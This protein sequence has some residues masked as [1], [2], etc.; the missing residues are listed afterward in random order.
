MS[1]SIRKKVTVPLPYLL[2]PE[3]WM[4]LSAKQR[5]GPADCATRMSVPALSIIVHIQYYS[6]W[7]SLQMGRSH[8]S[9]EWCYCPS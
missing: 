7:T 6:C 3:S 9:A 1:G 4:T 2:S 8:R 5:L